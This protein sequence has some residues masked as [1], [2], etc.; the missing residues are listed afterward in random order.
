MSYEKAGQFSLGPNKFRKTE[1]QPTHSGKV[2][3]NGKTYK[4]SGWVRENDN[5]KY[6]A[7]EVNVEVEKE[8]QSSKPN[9]NDPVGF[10]DI[11]F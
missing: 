7:G 1:K 8:P 3:I 5:G 10:D 9:R 4:L 2:T 6:I 11:G